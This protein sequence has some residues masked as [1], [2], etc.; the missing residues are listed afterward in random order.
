[1]RSMLYRSVLL[2][3]LLPV[4][5]GAFGVAVAPRCAAGQDVSARAYL[6]PATVGVGRSFNLNVEVTGS[7]NVESQPQLP[8]LAPHATYLGASTS[9]SMQVV[10]NRTTVSL[11]LQYRY[12]ALQEGTVEIPAL[13]ISVGGRTL[14]TEP[15]TLTIS[16]EPPPDPQTPGQAT[17]P[18]APGCWRV[19]RWWWSTASSRG[20][21]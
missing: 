19:S 3:V 11:T 7:Q 4:L 1:M 15:M 5:L 8:D 13:S 18:A 17:R 21:T 2:T 14:R 10:N 20:W 9:T 12:Q 6:N 16:A